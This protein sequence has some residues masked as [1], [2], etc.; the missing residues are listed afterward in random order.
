[1]H[2]FERNKKVTHFYLINTVHENDKKWNAYM[3]YGIVNKNNDKE[4]YIHHYN[5]AKI[6][7]AL[8]TEQQR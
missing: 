7:L 8:E 5:L 2:L 4:F 6:N 1:M 3:A